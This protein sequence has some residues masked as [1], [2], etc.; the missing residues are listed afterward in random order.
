M[1][2]SYPQS[3][4]A[5]RVRDIGF[6][7]LGAAVSAGASSAL[8]PAPESAAQT[9]RSAIRASVFSPEPESAGD[10]RCVAGSAAEETSS[11]ETSD[12]AKPAVLNPGETVELAHARS[13]LEASQDQRRQLQVRLRTAERELAKREQPPPYEYD[14]SRDQWRDLAAS[15]RI[16]YRMPCP[17]A[18][19]TGY[20]LGDQVLSA[21]GLSGQDGD[22]VM[23]ALHKSNARVWATVRPMCAELVQKDD[24][25]ELLGFDGCSTLIQRAAQKKDPL[26]VFDAQRAVAEVRAG[27]RQTPAPDQNPSP[28]FRMDLALSG[29]G[30]AFQ[31]DL[32]ESFGPDEAQRIWHSF[33]CARTVQ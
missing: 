32:A 30:D 4:P 6:L 20:K 19:N 21:L 28:L 29:E 1:V 10:E 26:A 3:A 11:D 25:V 8:K 15:G 33:P 22:A 23:D 14:L 18:P 17:L 13:E 12:A 16:K 2:T 31:A 27:L 7:V 5:R 24:L 9:Q